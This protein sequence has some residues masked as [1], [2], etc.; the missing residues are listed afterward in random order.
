M[1]GQTTDALD[2][3]VEPA[4]EADT[5]WMMAAAGAAGAAGALEYGRTLGPGMA[6]ACG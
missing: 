2:Q 1:I 6:F 4:V 5:H 3:A